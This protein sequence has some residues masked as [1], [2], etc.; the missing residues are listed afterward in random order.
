MPADTS[1]NS[2]ARR[3][4]Y[5][6]ATI[7]IT[8]G[9]G[10]IGGEL[11]RTLL[12]HRPKKVV[13]FSNDENGLFETRS[14][15]GVRPDVDYRLGDIRDMRGLETAMTGCDYVF[16]AA[17]LKHVN[18]CEVNP[19]EAI[20]TNTLGTQNVID[21]AISNKVKKFVFI[22]TDKAVNPI[23]T[24]GATK[25]LAEKLVISASKRGSGPG[26]LHREVW[27]RHREQR[28][29]GL[30]I[31]EAGPRGRADHSHRSRDD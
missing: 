14:S 8:G 12:A 6:G 10:S 25:L 17:A 26:V 3:S 24:L 28:V 4:A 30:D 5:S 16:H 13:V 23:N 15:V 18:F 31:R 1:A 22:S 27:Q 11:L 21:A 19:Y 2:G 7:L 20:S 29:R 9:T